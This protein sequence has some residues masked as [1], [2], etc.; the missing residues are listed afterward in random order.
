M[1]RVLALGAAAAAFT[2]SDER[3]RSGNDTS[4]PARMCS[5]ETMGDHRAPEYRAGPGM[6]EGRAES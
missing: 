4:E 2:D 6:R 5:E 3:E 1:L